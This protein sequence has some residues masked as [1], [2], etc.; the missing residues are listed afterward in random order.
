MGRRP[1]VE[2]PG[3]IYHV[4]HRGNNRESILSRDQDKNFLLEQ[5]RRVAN[6]FNLEVFAYVIMRNH[7][8]MEVRAGEVPLSTVMHRL[9]AKY[10]RYYNQ[11]YNRSGHVFEGRYKAIPIEDEAYL[12]TVLRYIHQNPV[13]AGF[14]PGVNQYRWSSDREYRGQQDGFVNTSFILGILGSNPRA[15]LQ[16]YANLM[17]EEL[18]LEAITS[19]QAPSYLEKENEPSVTLTLKMENTKP[20]LDD[21]LKSTG[22]NAGEFEE[23]KQGSRKREL[24]PFKRAFAHK[25]STYGYSLSEIGRAINVSGSAINR[26]LK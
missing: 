7:F 5:I 8:H 18:D 2:Y 20:T 25:A 16:T 11:E 14:C 13:R 12:L 10:S 17:E 9:N 4:Y 1:R 3:A 22:L 23:I 19:C 21:I 15:S 26:L 24:I 6:D